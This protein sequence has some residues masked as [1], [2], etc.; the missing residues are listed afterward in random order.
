VFRLLFFVPFILDNPIQDIFIQLL[1]EVQVSIT[2]S[3]CRTIESIERPPFRSSLASLLFI[4]W[5]MVLLGAATLQKPFCAQRSLK[6]SKEFGF[7][8][9]PQ[10]PAGDQRP[11]QKFAVEVF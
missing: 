11:L 8:L 5:H 9:N 6:I 1:G 7:K 4:A 3:T 10:M 2:V